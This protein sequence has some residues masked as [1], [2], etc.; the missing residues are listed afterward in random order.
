MPD[1]TRMSPLPCAVKWPATM[2]RLLLALGL[3]EFSIHPAS[4][5]EIKQAITNTSVRD[6]DGLARR[7]LAA[8]NGAEV[9]ELLE[10]TEQYP[11]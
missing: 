7:A 1:E 2:A 10:T 9:A 5:L 4:L 6:L 8:S 11:H 3:R